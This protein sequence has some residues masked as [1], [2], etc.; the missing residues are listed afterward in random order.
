[1][2]LSYFLKVMPVK[3]FYEWKS[4]VPH[5]F[6]CF[7]VRKTNN[8]LESK[9]SWTVGLHY[10][11]IHAPTRHGLPTGNLLS[12]QS[13]SLKINLQFVK[14]TELSVCGFNLNFILGMKISS[15]KRLHRTGT[16]LVMKRRMNPLQCLSGEC[17]YLNWQSLNCLINHK[18][19]WHAA[20]LQSQGWRAESC[21][22][23]NC[24]N[25]K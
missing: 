15:W 23:I 6:V 25:N 18:M 10:L 21:L 17:A 1:M 11:F 24:N 22:C 13:P 3:S 2:P 8:T 7:L 14:R 20:Q 19:C 16:G 9:S 12:M 5:F 4:F